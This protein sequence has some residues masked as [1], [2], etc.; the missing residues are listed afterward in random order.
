M[1]SLFEFRKISY[2]DNSLRLR[3]RKP[4]RDKDNRVIRIYLFNITYYER[5]ESR[6]E[7]KNNQGESLKEVSPLR[8]R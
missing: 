5:N 7:Q 4:F 1:F 8:E 3:T 6:K 2:R